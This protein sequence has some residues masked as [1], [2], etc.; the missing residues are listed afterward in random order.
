[1]SNL[2]PLYKD[3]I[4]ASIDPRKY[5]VLSLTCDSSNVYAQVQSV[6]VAPLGTY[7]VSTQVS[8]NDLVIGNDLDS[9]VYLTLYLATRGEYKL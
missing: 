5:R 1:M 4:A 3:K 6:S 9:A 8:G 7:I 2:L